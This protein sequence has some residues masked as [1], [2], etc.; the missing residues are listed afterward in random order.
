VSGAVTPAGSPGPIPDADARLRRTA[1]EFE[2]IF[3]AQLFREMRASLPEES[4][5]GGAGGDLFTTLLDDAV[6][7]E[8]AR[9]SSRGL[10]DALYRQLAARLQAPSSAEGE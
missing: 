1:Q 6:A 8:A 10:S 9:R 5:G 2:G 3:L 4:L 7:L